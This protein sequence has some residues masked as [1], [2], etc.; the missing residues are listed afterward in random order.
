MQYIEVTLQSGERLVLG[1]LQEHEIDV[2]FHSGAS[3]VVNMRK[4]RSGDIDLLIKLK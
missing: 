3:K 2:S 4:A 1:V